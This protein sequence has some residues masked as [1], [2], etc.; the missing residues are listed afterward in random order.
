MIAEGRFGKSSYAEAV[1]SGQVY[2]LALSKTPDAA[3]LSTIL[4]D[5]KTTDFGIARC[6]LGFLAKEG[7]EGRRERRENEAGWRVGC[8]GSQ[9]V[10][11][12]GRRA[13]RPGTAWPV[14]K[15]RNRGKQDQRRRVKKLTTASSTTAPRNDTIS[16]D[17]F[18]LTVKVP[19]LSKA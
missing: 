13:D 1:R 5:A 17:R 10:S 9:A 14:R 7:K 4:N 12:G 15:M 18:Q 19:P 2:K 8:I 16:E 3:P 6:G 11:I